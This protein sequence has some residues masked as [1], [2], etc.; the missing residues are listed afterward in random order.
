MLKL[1]MGA[2]A[3]RVIIRAQAGWTV[4]R[5]PLSVRVRDTV[6]LIPSAIALRTLD[7]C[8]HCSGTLDVASMSIMTAKGAALGT[9]P[10]MDLFMR[11][12]PCTTTRRCRTCHRVSI[13][14][15]GPRIRHRWGWSAE[16][17]R[18]RLR[19]WVENSRGSSRG[20]EYADA[21]YLAYMLFCHY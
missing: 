2:S 8:L 21:D 13:D 9:W 11:G 3:L 14:D 16:T 20:L 4:P 18:E 1:R 17:I 7:K 12:G 10:E 15:T 6:S 19:L 5:S